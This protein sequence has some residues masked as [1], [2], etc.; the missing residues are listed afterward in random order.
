MP[1]TVTEYLSTDHRRL[2]A[3]VQ[4][5]QD[6]AHTGAHADAA[7]AFARFA[8]GLDRHIRAEEEVLFPAFE[9]AVGAVGGPTAVGNPLSDD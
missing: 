5:V 6:A 2:D 9:E 7:A 1:S 4:E 3:I 8:E